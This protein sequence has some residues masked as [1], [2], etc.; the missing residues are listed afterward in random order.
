M[1]SSFR[2]ICLNHDPAILIGVDGFPDYDNVAEALAAGW[3]EHPRCLVIIGQ[4]SGGLV[5]LICPGSERNS[6]AEGLR[7]R[8][9]QHPAVHLYDRE[10]EPVWLRYL[11]MSGEIVRS[12]AGS[13]GCWTYDTAVKLKPI[14]CIATGA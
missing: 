9:S 11:A 2:P 4:W 7:H 13:T 5:E 14:L 1:S 3:A 6:P 12:A 10:V 8:Q